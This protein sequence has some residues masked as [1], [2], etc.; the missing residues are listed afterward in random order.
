MDI[1]G[2]RMIKPDL[3]Y[4]MDEVGPHIDLVG[5]VIEVGDKHPDWDDDWEEIKVIVQT[6]QGI[7]YGWTPRPPKVGYQATIRIYHV[8][9][10]W[11]P[12][13][14]IIGWTTQERVK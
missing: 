4:S 1:E 5:T 14:R 3:V 10:G 13:N 2:K 7:F 11:Y 12:D 9:G 8:G 6:E